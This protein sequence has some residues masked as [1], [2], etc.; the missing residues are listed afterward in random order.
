M[1][2][3]TVLIVDDSEMVMKVLTYMVQ[4]AGYNI[5][6]AA[7]GKSALKLMDGRDID[8]VIT[9]LNMPGMDGAALI[10][11]VRLDKEYAYVPA[12]LFYADDDLQRKEILKKSGAT[13]LFDK[14]N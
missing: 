9:D 11:T 7:D 2:T 1:Y 10:N 13:M 8:L 4:K 12:I 5:L 14:K 3:N 6:S